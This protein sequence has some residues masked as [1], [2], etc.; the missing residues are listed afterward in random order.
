V[1][2]AK[3]HE[4]EA[5]VADQYLGSVLKRPRHHDKFVIYMKQVHAVTW[6]YVELRQSGVIDDE[7]MIGTG[8]FAISEIKPDPFSRSAPDTALPESNPQ[9]V[10]LTRAFHDY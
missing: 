10:A 1:R 4:H 7:C 3:G 8:N 5:S 2:T 6:L 9:R